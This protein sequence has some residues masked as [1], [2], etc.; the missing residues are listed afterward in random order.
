MY[1]STGNLIKFEKFLCAVDF[2]KCRHSQLFEGAENE[3]L[4]S[5]QPPIGYLYHTPSPTPR[6]HYRRVDW[7]PKS[8]RSGRTRNS[9]GIFQDLCTYKLIVV[10][11]AYKPAQEHRSQHSSMRQKFMSPPSLSEDLGTFGGFWEREKQFSLRVWV[12]VG[13]VYSS[14]WSTLTS[15]WKVQI[16]V[17]VSLNYKSKRT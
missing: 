11:A 12:F 6:D 8:Q 15:I 13:W 1:L 10:L 4:W 17:N 5:A 3:W 14:G 9:S 16:S 7:G 2:G